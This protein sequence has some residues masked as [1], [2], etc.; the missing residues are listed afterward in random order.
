MKGV[1]LIALTGYGHDADRERAK[2]AGFDH[3]FVKPVDPQALR[4]LLGALGDQIGAR[5]TRKPRTTSW[6]RAGI[7]R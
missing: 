6:R 7:R 4:K 3:H 1:V 2:A 5:R